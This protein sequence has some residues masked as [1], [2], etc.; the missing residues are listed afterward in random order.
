MASMKLTGKGRRRL[1][2]GHPWIYRD[3]IAVGTA[4]AGDLVQVLAP[5]GDSLG[6]ALYSDASRIALRLVTRGE[7]QPTREFWQQR[8]QRAVDARARVG[9]LEPDGACRLL[10]GDSEGL[11]GMVV[12]R[13]GKVI[14]LQLGTQAADRMGEFL[15]ELVRAALPFEL[16]AVVDRSDT[17]AR[18]LEN[19]PKR[20]EV[21]QGSVEEAPVTVML[22]IMTVLSPAAAWANDRFTAEADAV[23]RTVFT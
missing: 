21:I 22:S 12:D 9:M 6:W 15:V 19:L 16:D 13:Y 7:Q 18:K 3:D 1:L 8:V 4:Q 5:A 10:A 20:S 2:G 14:V 23:K 17:A 11:P